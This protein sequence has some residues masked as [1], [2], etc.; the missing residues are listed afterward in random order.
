MDV[1]LKGQKLTNSIRESF[2]S[3]IQSARS[4]M[5][6]IDALELT[7]RWW[8]NNHATSPKDNSSEQ[9]EKKKKSKAK[10]VVTDAEE[11]E[12]AQGMKPAQAVISRVLWDENLPVDRFVVGYID[13]Y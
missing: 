13:R 10:T 2:N 7:D 6:L 12:A 9:S 4:K 8:T 1:F 5:D 3:S 11:T